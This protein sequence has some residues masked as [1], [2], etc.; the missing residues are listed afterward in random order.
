MDEEIE[1]T[2]VQSFYS[3][4]ADS[5]SRTRQKI[6]P[7]TEKFI[8]T[9]Y[10]EGFLILDSGCGNGR[11]M[12]TPMVGLDTS[13]ELLHFCKAKNAFG[14]FNANSISLPFVDESFDL[15]LSIAVIHHLYTKERRER[16]V[17]EIF[18]VMKAKSKA[19]ICVWSDCILDKKKVLK[20]YEDK[21]FEQND[22]FVNWNNSKDNFRYYHLFKLY[23]LNDLLMSVGFRVLEHGIENE[24]YYVI[25]EKPG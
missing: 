4:N 3:R 18:R 1:K 2:Y 23:E 6:W 17:K 19:F 11:S 8:Q 9:N 22:V 12:I 5:F 15:L 13:I 20:I 10:V 24:S 16:A 25:V 21:S 14:L 7:S